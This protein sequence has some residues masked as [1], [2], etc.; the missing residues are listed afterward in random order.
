[1]DTAERP[2]WS[3]DRDGAHDVRAD[4]A[5]RDARGRSAREGLPPRWGV[6][7]GPARGRGCLLRR[8]LADGP[9]DSASRSAADLALHRRISPRGMARARHSG[10][11]L[12]RRHLCRSGR[13]VGLASRGDRRRCR[14]GRCGADRARGL[15]ES[16]PSVLA[17][18]AGRCAGR[19]RRARDRGRLA[20]RWSHQG[21]VATTRPFAAGDGRLHR[22][23]RRCLGDRRVGALRRDAD[24]VRP[25]RFGAG[26]PEDRRR[27]EDRHVPHHRTRR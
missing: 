13:G 17:R 9:C 20:P 18:L 24:A 12:R 22:G 1:M 8:R 11:W 15:G 3:H 25:G 23:G 16:D 27:A 10:P 7:A 21:I 19:D 26:V 2:F 4:R 14:S 5:A 6:A